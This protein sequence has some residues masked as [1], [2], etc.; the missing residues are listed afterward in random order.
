MHLAKLRFTSPSSAKPETTLW[1][2]RKSSSC[3]LQSWSKKRSLSPTWKRWFLHP[4]FLKNW[5]VIPLCLCR[6]R[7][8]RGLKLKETISGTS[9]EENLP[10]LLTRLQKKGQIFLIRCAFCRITKISI[11]TLLPECLQL[12]EMRLKLAEAKSELETTEKQWKY[13]AEEEAER[14]HSK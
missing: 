9:W 6:N 11:F 7:S 5:H 13:Q 10:P 14:I 2:K 4:V 1:P 12:A 3:Y 8:T